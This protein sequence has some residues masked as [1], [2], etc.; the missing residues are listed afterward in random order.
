MAAG[1]AHEINTPA[2]F[3][4]DNIKY[5]QDA[6]VDINKLFD[7]YDVL[8][9]GLSAI[10]LTE[11]TK[12]D[13]DGIASCSDEIDLP[14]IREDIPV[15]IS[16]A[17]DGVSRIASIVKA[18]K[19]FS[20]P[21]TET[22]ELVSLNKAIDSTLT[23]ARNEWK[24]CA[25]ISRE[26]DQE[27]PMVECHIGELNQVILNM[28]VNGA[29]AIEDQQKESGNTSLGCI[30]IRTALE[31]NL[32]VIQISDTGAGIEKE[33]IKKIFEPFFTTKSVGKGSGQGL[34][35][36]Y[37]VVVEKHNG[38]I[39]VE[40]EVGS[41]TTFTI[42][43]PIKSEKKNDDIGINDIGINDIGIDDIGIDEVEDI[44]SSETE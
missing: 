5:F 20:H 35:I 19:E 12:K 6:F 26:F 23:V 25:E 3:I 10:E 4:G 28:I 11:Q 42:K 16:Q 32:V 18:M 29:H 38:E 44:I 34:Y 21:G 14:F 15:A 41:G 37:S 17:L 7:S 9:A 39:T 33:N 22:K 27:L 1:I 8:L 30:T 36:A 2:Q 31:E 43:L 24:Y 13:V 40:S